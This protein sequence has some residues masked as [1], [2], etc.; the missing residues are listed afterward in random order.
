MSENII[1]YGI[2]NPRW[3]DDQFKKWLSTHCPE[4]NFRP[5][6]MPK[7]LIIN[8]AIWIKGQFIRQTGFIT[9]DEESAQEM[10]AC[11]VSIHFCSGVPQQ[12][13][14]QEIFKGYL[15]TIPAKA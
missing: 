6:V 13:I 10:F 14:F 15:R 5:M 2:V 4:E 11:L 3:A 9:V 7:E 12:D 8:G 1:E